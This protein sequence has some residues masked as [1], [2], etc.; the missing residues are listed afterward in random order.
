MKILFCGDVVGRTGR[1]AIM[2]NLPYLKKKLDLDFIIVNG[3][4]SAHGFGITPKICEEFFDIGVDVVVLG[5]H[6]WDQKEIIPYIDKQ[7][8][9]LRP[10]N[11]P[12]GTAGKGFGIYENRK[13]QKILVAQVMGRLF[14]EAIDCPFRAI[15]K[16]F[17]ENPLGKNGVIASI[18]DIHAE[19][20]SEKMAFGHFCDGFVS[21]VVGS[22]T[23][24]PTADLQILPKGTAYITDVGMCGDY[25][26][27]IGMQKEEPLSRFLKGFKS[28]KLVPADG[29][30]TFCG[31]FV[32]TNDKT[33]FA[34][35]VKPIYIGG[36]LV[37]STPL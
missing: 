28:S 23:H 22:H 35:N 3:E 26:S 18:V 17:K 13:G 16:V 4:N 24:I 33:G 36:R 29:D 21:A 12:E 6:T 15:E 37:L 30:A 32:E 8:R 34:V 2:G 14:L 19:C 25:N 9:L 20:T 10:L 1:D 5:N 31:V 27:V 7:N 11:Y